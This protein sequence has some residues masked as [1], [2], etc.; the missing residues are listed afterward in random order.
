MQVKER[1]AP[2]TAVHVRDIVKQIYAGSSS[3]LCWVVI[4]CCGQARD[5][6]RL[7]PSLSVVPRRNGVRVEGRRLAPFVPAHEIIIFR[8]D[9]MVC[10]IAQD[11]RRDT[12]QHL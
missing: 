4:G 3:A 7:G 10:V 5:P 12:E 1:G 11:L 2:A 6:G 8:T 9:N